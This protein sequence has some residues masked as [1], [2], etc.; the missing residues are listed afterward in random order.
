MEAWGYGVFLISPSHFARQIIILIT[1]LGASQFSGAARKDSALR[2]ALPRPTKDKFFLEKQSGSGVPH[3][4]QL[5]S[6]GIVWRGH[7]H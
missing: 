5:L 7:P 3:L 2:R 4:P 1:V 6:E